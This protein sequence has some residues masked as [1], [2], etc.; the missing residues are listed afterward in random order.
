M[1][2][3]ETS[4]L[5]QGKD[6]AYCLLIFVEMKCNYILNCLVARGGCMFTS[7]VHN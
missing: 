2:S 7:Q 5:Q 1:G 4:P 3:L 6:L